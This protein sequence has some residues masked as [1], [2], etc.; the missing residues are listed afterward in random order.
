MM[1]IIMKI[2]IDNWFERDKKKLFY[3]FALLRMNAF[4]H[5]PYNTCGF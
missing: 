3:F 1:Y 2:S 5:M 4:I